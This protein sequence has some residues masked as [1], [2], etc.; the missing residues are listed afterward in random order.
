VLAKVQALKDK[1]DE[2]TGSKAR[3]EAELE[4]LE[5]KLNRAEKLVTGLA[6]ERARQRERQRETERERERLR[7]GR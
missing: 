2:S 3:L 6:G 4:D 1:Y 7:R 5:L